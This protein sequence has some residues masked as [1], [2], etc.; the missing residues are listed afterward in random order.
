MNSAAIIAELLVR[1][2]PSAIGLIEQMVV[3]ARERQAVRPIPFGRKHDW[4]ILTTPPS[5]VYCKTQLTA[6]N[7]DEQC[8]GPPMAKGA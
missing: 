4:T 2:L 8:P 1:Y 6:T 5:C 7:R 3:Q